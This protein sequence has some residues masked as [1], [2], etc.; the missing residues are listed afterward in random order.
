MLKA[1]S[2]EDFKK[3]VIEKEGLSMVEFKTEWSGT[4]RI[5]EPVYTDLSK[6]YSGTIDFFTIDI[7]SEK[8]LDT[9][10]GVMEIPTILFFKA[11]KVIDHS[12]GLISKNRL[13]AK[14]ENVLAVLNK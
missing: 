12:I 4:C 1:I 10:Y 2:K 7:D 6:S 9:E 13:I 14:I 11:G 3:E 5:I 8:G